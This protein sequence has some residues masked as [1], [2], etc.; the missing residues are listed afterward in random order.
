VLCGGV[1]RRLSLSQQSR[2][3]AS[4]EEHFVEEED[5]GQPT[6]SMARQ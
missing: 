4:A 2:D 3:I 5:C 1:G 6:V